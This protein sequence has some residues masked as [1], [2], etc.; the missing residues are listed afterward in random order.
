MSEWADGWMDGWLTE[1]RVGKL[2]D[3][4]WMVEEQIDGWRARW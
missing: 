2:I 4:E 1:G 3:N